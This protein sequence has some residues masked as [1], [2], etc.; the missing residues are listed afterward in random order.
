MTKTDDYYNFVYTQDDTHFTILTLIYF[1][2][3]EFQHLSQHID[4]YCNEL[5]SLIFLIELENIVAVQGP[6]TP[7][8]VG[9][10]ATYTCV[11]T[12]DFVPTLQWLDKL[13][14]PVTTSGDSVWTLPQ[15]TIGSKTY[16]KLNF[17]PVKS[18]HGGSYTCKSVIT[19]SSS[20]NSTSRRVLVKRK[21]NKNL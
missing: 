9:R 20:T 13:N 1:F 4:S 2:T 10:N 5:F 16:M 21:C 12:S 8:P 17:N 6:S 15:Y 18:S 3:D 7:I 19:H 14:N 11:I